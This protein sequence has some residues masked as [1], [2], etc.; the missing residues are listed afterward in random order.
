MRQPPKAHSWGHQIWWW[1]P[2]EGFLGAKHRL[3]QLLVT[4]L[5]TQASGPSVGWCQGEW[6]DWGGQWVP[7]YENVVQGFCSRLLV[8]PLGLLG[9]GVCF[10]P[11]RPAPHHAHVTLT[12]T[13]ASTHR[14]RALGWRHWGSWW[15]QP[16]TVPSQGAL[17]LCS[18]VLSRCVGAH[19]CLFQ[20]LE[21]MFSQL[22][23]R[24]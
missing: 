1:I 20:Q 17:G 19:L 14:D 16:G 18:Q 7:S 4:P 23:N 21:K 9:R 13:L 3:S 11:S 12:L 5:L 8:N 10:S 24:N 2:L 6:Q 15:P 22:E